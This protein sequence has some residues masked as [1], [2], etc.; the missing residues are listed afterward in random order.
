[1]SDRPTAMDHDDPPRML[2]SASTACQK[3][4]V[5][6]AMALAIVPFAWFTWRYVLTETEVRWIIFPLIL[7]LVA[8]AFAAFAIVRPLRRVR[9]D[10][11][12]LYISN[13]RTEI[14]VPLSEVK[15]VS[16]GEY[17]KSTHERAYRNVV[18]TLASPTIL[19][20]SIAFR[21][22]MQ[23]TW[24]QTSNMHPVVDEIRHAVRNAR[25][26]ERRHHSPAQTGCHEAG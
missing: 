2:S 18:I 4:I 12:S 7:A 11:K 21:P 9:M 17:W 20:T 25:A 6:P 22:K 8:V 23:F 3:L 15:A 26:R 14:V 13:Y 5:P 24:A 1:M 19:G 16:G 10:G